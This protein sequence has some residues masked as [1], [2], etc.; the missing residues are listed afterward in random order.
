MD[1]FNLIK[2]VN[3]TFFDKDIPVIIQKLRIFHD[4]ESNYK[5]IQVKVTNHSNKPIEEI[6]FRITN[7]D[8]TK[9][10]LLVWKNIKIAP[11]QTISNDKPIYFETEFDAAFQVQIHEAIRADKVV[12]KSASNFEKIPLKKSILK[13]KLKV[14]GDEFTLNYNPITVKENW[15]CGCG[16]IN[17]NKDQGCLNCK[18]EKKVVFNKFKENQK[19]FR[20]FSFIF[21]GIAVSFPL[22]NASINLITNSFSEY[23][24]VKVSNGYALAEYRGKEENL[25]IPEMHRDLPVLAINKNA[26]LKAPFIKNLTIPDSV[27]SMEPGALAC[28]PNLKTLTTPFIGVSVNSEFDNSSLVDLFLQ[29]DCQDRFTSNDLQY[30][31]GEFK[32]IVPYSL[33]TINITKQININNRSGLDNIET[34]NLGS[35]TRSL[36]FNL[37]ELSKLKYVNAD[38]ANQYF[39]SFQG[40]LYN[41]NFKEIIYYSNN[42]TEKTLNLVDGLKIIPEYAFDGNKYLEDLVVPDSVDII[43]KGAFEGINLK[44][45]SVPFIGFSRTVL[46]KNIAHFFS[47]AFVQEDT[48]SYY[49]FVPRTL[50]NLVVTDDTNISIKNLLNTNNIENITFSNKTSFIENGAFDNLSGLK[51]ITMI[52][53]NAVYSSVDGVLYSRDQTRL[54]KFPES[55]Y[56]LNFNVPQSVSIID[57]TALKNAIYIE[58][59]TIPN[60]VSSIEKGSFSGLRNLKSLTVPYIGK[61]RESKELEG[62]LGHFFGQ[63]PYTGGV[64]TNQT[65]LFSNAANTDYTFYIPRYLT[66]IKVNDAQRISEGAFSRISTLSTITLNEGVKEIG[67]L[68]LFATV[69]LT[70]FNIPTTT[71]KIG[72]GVFQRSGLRE[73]FIPRSVVELGFIQFADNEPIREIRVAHNFKP[74]FWNN[75]WNSYNYPVKWGQQS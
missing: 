66:N 35:S 42:R 9:Q 39:S 53:G 5:F 73:L 69:G 28:L 68:A 29:T 22:L 14:S 17:H 11:S 23:R 34:L 65:Y 75:N 10:E 48:T 25:V 4:N 32:L 46:D 61:N 20:V 58:I 1:R 43:Y 50:T 74:S 19:T 13:S 56:S 51:N 52:S 72:N 15:R 49:S 71:T 36:N 62:L 16:F 54:I 59:L 31:S 26:F 40:V 63:D 7:L 12:Y 60:S 47:G 64:P 57:K 21:L 33:S 45:L 55:K 2:E 3:A 18:I 38:N 44:S 37:H 8:S 67:D 41:K 27:S 24:Y 6:T 70:S 30:Q